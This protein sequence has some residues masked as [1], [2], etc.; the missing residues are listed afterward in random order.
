MGRDDD[1]DAVV[2]VGQRGIGR[3]RQKDRVARKGPGQLKPAVPVENRRGE[4]QSAPALVDKIFDR[5]PD[6]CL[7]WNRRL[8]EIEDQAGVMPRQF[9]IAVR[10]VP[11]KGVVMLEPPA[12]STGNK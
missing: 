12:G 6:G 1:V 7:R 3:W 9:P 2:Q 4:A 11:A 8:A 10:E 5:R